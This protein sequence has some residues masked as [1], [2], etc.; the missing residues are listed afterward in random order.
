MKSDE[1]RQFINPV[2]SFPSSLALHPSE[3]DEL[4]I[5]YMEPQLVKGFARGFRG[6]CFLCL[7]AE[8]M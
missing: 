6:G 1:L 3:S 8:E 2:G 7:Q 5:H 4:K